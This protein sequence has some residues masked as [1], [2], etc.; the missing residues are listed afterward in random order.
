MT[1]AAKEATLSEWF[2]QGVSK[3]MAYM[4]VVCDS[5]SYEDYPVFTC[6]DV[7]EFGKAYKASTSNMQRVREVYDLNMDKNMQIWET[8]AMHLPCEGL[9]TPS[10]PTATR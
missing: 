4:I 5:F 9:K 6:A 1:F 3:G 7:E 2:D 8:Q 10:P